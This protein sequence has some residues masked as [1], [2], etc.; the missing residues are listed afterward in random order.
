MARRRESF[1]SL[2]ALVLIAALVAV[3]LYLLFPRQAV[4]E[5]MSYLDNPDGLSIAYLEVLLRSD[6]DNTALRINLAHMLVQSGQ[7]DRAAEVLRPLVNQER[8]PSLAMEK[9]LSLHAKRVYAEPPGPGR[10]A[11]RQRLFERAQQVLSQPYGF[12]R[13]QQLIRPSHQWLLPEQRL[14]LLEGLLAL[15]PEPWQQINLARQIAHL[16][17][18]QG[19]PGAA[20]DTLRQHLALVQPGRRAEYIDNLIRLELAGG[21]PRQALELFRRY[22][23]EPPMDIAALEQGVRLATLAGARQQRQRWLQQLARQ[24]PDDLE[25]QRE[26]LALQLGEGEVSAALATLRRMQ[27]QEDQLTLAD[28][29]RLAQ[30]LEWNDRPEE[31]LE[32]WRSL[33]RQT[34]ETEALDRAMA[35]A[36]GLFRWPTLLDLLSRGARRNQLGPDDFRLWADALVREGR[37]DDARQRLEQGM[38]RFPTNNELTDRRLALLINTRDF[39]EAIRML[40][41]QPELSASQRIELARLYWRTRQPEKAL[42]LL[43]F[44]PDDPVLADIVEALRL[45]LATLL[46]RTDL[47]HQD[48]RRLISRPEAEDRQLDPQ[49]LE[50]LLNLAVLFEDYPAAI[51]LA[52]RRFQQTGEARY[53]AA[54]AEY[55]LAL[56]DWRALERTLER[57][58]QYSPVATERSR[59]WAL[60]ALLHQRHGRIA[61]ANQAYQRAHALAPDDQALLIN[62]AWLQLSDPQQFRSTLPYLLARLEADATPTAYPVLAFGHSALGEPWRA[63]HWFQLGLAER[64]D[65]VSWLVATAR[66]MEQTGSPGLATDLRQQA[67][68]RLGR[69]QFPITDQL[70]VYQAEGMT[71]QAWQLLA[72]N[73][74]ATAEAAANRLRAV[75]AFSL[76]QDE[77]LVAEALVY[78]VVPAD[79]DLR[80]QLQ[81]SLAPEPES[82]VEQVARLNRQLDRL[83]AAASPDER[84]A[85]LRDTLL[86]ARSFNRAVQVGSEWQDL[87]SFGVARQGVAAEYSLETYRWAV[88]LDEV[89]HRGKGS[90]RRSPGSGLEARVVLDRPAPERNWSLALARLHREGDADLSAS[91]TAALQPWDRVGLNASLHYRERTPDSAEAWW[92]TS[93]NRVSLG[94]S[95]APFSRLS[96][97]VR[98]DQMSVD[99]VTGE[100]LG[101]GSGVDLQTTYTLFRED[102]AWTLSA[103]YR[104]QRLDVAD[105]LPPA[106][107]QALAQPLA[108][109][110]LLAED[111][112]RIGLNTRWF[113]G[114]PH[115]LYRTAPSPRAFF[116]L[117][118]GYVLSTATPDFGLELGL[119]W[120]VVGDDELALS[121]RWSS[122]GLDGNGRTDINLT[123]TIHLG[124]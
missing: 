117:G 15:A 33:Y 60:L 35:L 78:Q 109:E 2:P 48:Y 104:R 20:A 112:E 1:F 88:D 7:L 50:R 83:G 70:A 95:Y 74:T 45:D 124:R 82:R 11:L 79:A 46:G 106:T 98:L 9:W 73:G 65:D 85:L 58:R 27:R 80:R 14:A 63:R 24:R 10:E 119:G 71:R 75:A 30:V 51:D 67:A 28:R 31:A 47:L 55:H 108:P 29:R 90:L 39:E 76:Q 26:L 110:T 89:S 91:I 53:L 19:N 12:E 81:A 59:Y 105:R 107:S 92:L 111:Y 123:Y 5:D 101:D 86:L 21:N 93:R 64:P 56:E 25:L 23:S 84:R 34:G 6:S 61:D 116:G 37:L 100:N 114:E 69:D 42:P 115:A 13:K 94:A 40:E 99:T 8:V 87:G 41:Q 54:L 32:A 38:A 102:P 52:E 122:E 118:A 97:S 49:L 103:G 22:R 44:S 121:G 3:V 62:W 120:R 36:E 96:T 4:F 66:V 68:E 113:H 57:W 72:D 17:E 18:S 16:Q 43:E 77:P